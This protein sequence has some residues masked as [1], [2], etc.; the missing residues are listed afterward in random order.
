MSMKMQ[1][2]TQVEALERRTI[3]V[4]VWAKSKIT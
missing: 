1:K 2:L 4:V 3:E